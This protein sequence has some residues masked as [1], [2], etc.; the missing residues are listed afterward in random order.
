MKQ[1]Q[2]FLDTASVM[3]KKKEYIQPLL[4]TLGKVSELTAGGFSGKTEDSNGDGKCDSESKN[5]MRC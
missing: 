2:A 4:T 1:Q 3:C 5:K